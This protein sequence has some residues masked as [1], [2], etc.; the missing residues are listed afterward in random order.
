MK[1]RLTKDYIGIPLNIYDIHCGSEKHFNLCKGIIAKADALVVLGHDQGLY[2]MIMDLVE[3]ASA[4]GKK[5]LTRE[6]LVK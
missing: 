6:D 2:P 5:V 3:W 1:Y 4:I